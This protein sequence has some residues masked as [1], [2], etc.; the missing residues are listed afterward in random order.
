MKKQ[1]NILFLIGSVCLIVLILMF[2]NGTYK[3][4]VLG[5]TL[6]ARQDAQLNDAQ[7]MSVLILGDS[8]SQVD[9]N[10]SLIDG[11]FNFASNGETYVQ[12]YY[13]LRYLIEKRGIVPEVIVL[14]FNLYSFS[15]YRASRI[16]D[17]WYW[18]RIVNYSEFEGQF[19][20][21]NFFDN[22]LKA[23][24]PLAGSGETMIALIFEGSQE[25]RQGHYS[26]E[27]SFSDAPDKE[28]IGL[29]R[30]EYHFKDAEIIH[31]GLSYYFK[32]II[33]IAEKNNM[34]VILVRYPLT[35]VY[36]SKAARYI[37]NQNEFYDD[38]SYQYAKED[39]VHVL[40]YHLWNYDDHSL[41]A[42]S[43]HLNTKGS[44]IFSKQFAKDIESIKKMTTPTKFE[45]I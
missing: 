44:Q 36:Q 42:D 6:L 20:K 30:V 29:Q 4:M 40:D 39:H 24:F 45:I 37:P 23:R 25:I 15:S 17:V 9:V 41:F 10:P 34:T 3:T 27:K 16:Q 2:L 12:N 14:P 7:N 38:V 11:S 22:S 8:S 18:H 21:A 5:K 19:G 13:K 28:K 1:T 32:K 33:T 31:P 26:M 43:M 35:D